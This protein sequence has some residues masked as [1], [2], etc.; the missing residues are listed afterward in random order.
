M[1]IEIAIITMF[2]T[3]TIVLFITV[4]ARSIIII[5]DKRQKQKSKKDQFKEAARIGKQRR[6]EREKEMEERRNWKP[7]RSKLYISKTDYKKGD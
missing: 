4:I 7:D 6:R 1:N 2:I 5:A 3:A